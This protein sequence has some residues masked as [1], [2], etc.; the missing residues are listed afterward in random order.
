[1]VFAAIVFIIC[2]FYILNMVVGLIVGNA[3]CSSFECGILNQELSRNLFSFYF[4][5][6]TILFLLFDIELCCLVP[7]VRVKIMGASLL[8]LLILLSTYVELK[9]GVLGWVLKE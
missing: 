5:Y 2:V 7:I 1:M 8:L 4:F 9:D 3:S 6:L